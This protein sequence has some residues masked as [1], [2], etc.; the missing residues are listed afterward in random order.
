MSSCI[1]LTAFSWCT[2]AELTLASMATTH[3]RRV[4]QLRVWPCSMA[5]E[6]SAGLRLGLAGAEERL[7][8]L[9]LDSGQI[10]NTRNLLHLRIDYLTQLN[11]PAMLVAS[12]DVGLLSTLSYSYL[13]PDDLAEQTTWRMSLV[14]LYTFGCSVSLGASLWVLYTCNNLTNLATMSTIAA[15]DLKGLQGADIVLSLRMTDVR[16]WFML[17]LASMVLGLYAMVVAMMEPIIAVPATLMTVCCGLH[18]VHAEHQTSAHFEKVSGVHLDAR[19]EHALGQGLYRVAEALRCLTSFGRA[20]RDGREYDTLG[21][22]IDEVF[23][24]RYDKRHI[25]RTLEEAT[26]VKR[27]SSRRLDAIGARLLKTSSK[28]GPIGLLNAVAFERDPKV[29]RQLL[30]Y[31]AANT[32]SNAGY[33]VLQGPIFLCF[34]SEADWVADAN[35]VHTVD[36]HEYTVLSVSDTEERLTIALLPKIVLTVDAPLDRA[37]RIDVEQAGPS[38]FICSPAG[39]ET[40]TWFGRLQAVCDESKV[41]AALAGA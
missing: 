1:M 25:R 12:A 34:R 15:K 37:Y 19:A 33:W 21:S 24:R 32:P 38:W 14:F 2:E 13:E 6:E 5:D 36:L 26:A 9:Q 23:E 17:S 40:R 11:T 31:T 18:A 28:K 16:S 8:G 35:P 22:R 4:G 41:A 30:T 27:A 7:F 3:E 20:G 29:R 39:A 10:S